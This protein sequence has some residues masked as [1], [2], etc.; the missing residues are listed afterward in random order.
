MGRDSTLV[1][2]WSDNSPRYFAAA[3]PGS[4]L[5]LRCEVRRGSE[6]GTNEIREDAIL[7]SASIGRYTSLAWWRVVTRTL[8]EAY[9]EALFGGLADSLTDNPRLPRECQ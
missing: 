8:G 6:P 2:G 7:A 4:E 5:L 1:L 3:H 9:A